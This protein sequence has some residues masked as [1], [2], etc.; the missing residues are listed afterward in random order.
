MKTMSRRERWAEEKEE[1][2]S[3]RGEVGGVGCFSLRV[4]VVV[5]GWR[6]QFSAFLA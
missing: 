3:K 4:A 1:A 5:V 6:Y 2:N